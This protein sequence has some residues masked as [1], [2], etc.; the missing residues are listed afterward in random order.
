MWRLIEN[1]VF[2]PRAVLQSMRLD[3]VREGY[4]AILDKVS[5]LPAEQTVEAILQAYGFTEEK[6]PSP[7][8]VAEEEFGFVLMP[9]REDMEGLYREVIRPTVETAG[10]ACLRADDLF[11]TNRIMDDIEQFIGS[12]RF[13]IADLS[14]RNPNVF[15]EVGMSH[16]W[17][18]KVILLAQRRDDVPFDVRQ[19]RLIVYTDDEKGRRK[20]SK[21]LSRTI[22]TITRA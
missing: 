10:F 9:F 5:T 2:E 17:R 22:E 19:W 14:G 7:S 6:P 8:Q 3:D 4:Y 18:K 15:Y 21:S 16:A 11:T 13:I 1:H 12:A 20:L